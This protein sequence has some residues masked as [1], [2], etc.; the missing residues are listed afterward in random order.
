MNY[1]AKLKNESFEIYTLF[2]HYYKLGKNRKL[3]DILNKTNRIISDL[4]DYRRIY[5]WDFRIKEY[6]MKNSNDELSKKIE[7]LKNS[8]DESELLFNLQKNLNRCLEKLIDLSK[9]ENLFTEEDDNINR[10]S[11]I[12]KVLRLTN[13]YLTISD[14]IDKRI[15][16]VDSNEIDKLERKIEKIK[17]KE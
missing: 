1:P 12:E 7:E 9:P 8:S 3:E 4:E 14:R 17:L 6:E 11:K 5:N 10:I 13:L 16:K 15:Y 2:K